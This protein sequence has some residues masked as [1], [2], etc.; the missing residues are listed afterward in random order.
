MAKKPAATRVRALR[1]VAVNGKPVHVGEE[2]D[3]PRH[4]LARW[5][6]KGRVEVVEDDKPAKAKAPKRAKPEKAP[7]APKTPEPVAPPPAP[8]A[9][10]PTTPAEPVAGGGE[11]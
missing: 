9:P 7:A 10:S 11:G 6:A 5:V 2:F 3:I 1:K 4:A 8:P